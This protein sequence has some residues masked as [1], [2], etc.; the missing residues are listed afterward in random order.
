MPFC[1]N[2]NFANSYYEKY[3][4][5]IAHISGSV[6]SESLV[7]TS[8]FRI[9]YVYPLSNLQVTLLYGPFQAMCY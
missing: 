9:S 5:R 1:S 3:E 2:Y 8:S 7:M 6:A 4:K